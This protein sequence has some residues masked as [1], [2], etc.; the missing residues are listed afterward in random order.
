MLITSLLV[1]TGNLEESTPW[2]MASS[3]LFAISNFTSFWYFY[4]AR[5]L[6]DA[7]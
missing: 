2:W 3:L 1:L 5:Q 7:A 6:K 4:R